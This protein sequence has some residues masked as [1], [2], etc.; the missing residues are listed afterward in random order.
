MTSGRVFF[1]AVHRDLSREELAALDQ[2]S[3]VVRRGVPTATGPWT[4]AFEDIS[5]PTSILRVHADDE[6]DAQLR[7]VAT[8]GSPLDL[9]VRPIRRSKSRRFS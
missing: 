5:P 9:E 4:G 7:V 1:V 3:I 8:L 2:A 6:D